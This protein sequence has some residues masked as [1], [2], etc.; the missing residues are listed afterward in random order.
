M[1][2]DEF[3]NGGYRVVNAGGG[4][5]PSR[6]FGWANNWSDQFGS[7]GNYFNASW[8]DI[9]GNALSGN[10]T[11]LREGTYLN[12]GSGGVA[13]YSPTDREAPWIYNKWVKDYVPTAAILS[14]DATH[15]NEAYRSRAANQ[16]Q[17][18]L[19]DI[20]QSWSEMRLAKESSASAESQDA[21][22]MKTA[23]AVNGITQMGTTIA[24]NGPKPLY[25][26]P[27]AWSGMTKA[28]STFGTKLGIAGIA[29]TGVD[30]A[31]QGEWKP[32]HT[33]D[34]VIGAALTAGAMIPGVNVF[35]GIAGGVYFVSD[36]AW[37]FYSGKSI[38]ESLFDE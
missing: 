10:L 19:N 15:Q 31:I 4:Y 7:G 13:F 20:S 37:Q 22:W 16:Q 3:V 8:S 26:G 17:R 27:K 21:S 9:V 29:L 30:A 24:V 5:I 36:L 25:K 35:V 18:F 23:V 14:F 34:A 1:Q 32:H 28:G 38:T 33:A 6:A 12:D 2:D 11:G